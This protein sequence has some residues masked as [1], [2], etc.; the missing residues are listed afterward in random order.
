MNLATSFAQLNLLDLW[1]Q[2]MQ[3]WGFRLTPPSLDRL[4]CLALHRLGLM[5]KAE[6]K[7]FA[8]WIRPGMTIIDIGANQ[9]LYALLF[10][11]LVG[12]SGRVL[13]FEPE[14]DMFAALTRNCEV[15]SAFNVECFQFALGARNTRAT[16]TRSLVH[17]GDNRIAAADSRK[18][19]RA[20]DIKVAPLDEVI[21]DKS[22]DFIKMDV[23]GWELEV[24]R[25]MRRT[26]ERNRN[27]QIA[28]EFWPQGLR[29]AGCQPAD[30]LDHLRSTGFRLFQHV[31]GEEKL[32]LNSDL[33]S[34]WTGQHFTDIYA[35]R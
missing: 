26:L 25:G 16:L 28:F 21:G 23:Q 35:R 10:S 20:I 7:L 22:V 8:Q 5:G 33:G 4:V 12:A 27:L 2:E 29:N 13:A 32:L 31:N 15:N 18:I 1:K 11:E 6:K 17:A 34:N 3:V 9:G 24:L 14:P 30:L 19:T